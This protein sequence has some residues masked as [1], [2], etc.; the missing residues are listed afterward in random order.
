VQQYKLKAEL[1]LKKLDME[2]KKMEHKFQLHM[3]QMGYPSHQIGSSNFESA[4]NVRALSSGWSDARSVTVTP[5]TS[6]LPE[7]RDSNSTQFN[8][9]AGLDYSHLGGLES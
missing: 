4:S 6:H 1:A 3:A 5:S 7:I 8:F 9:Y 2:A